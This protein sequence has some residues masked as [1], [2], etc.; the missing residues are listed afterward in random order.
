MPEAKAVDLGEAECVGRFVELSDRVHAAGMAIELVEPRDGVAGAAPTLEDVGRG[1]VGTDV[2]RV[3]GKARGDHEHPRGVEY[4]GR[5]PRGF[6]SKNVK[7]NG[8]SN[9]AN[10]RRR[11]ASAQPE[12]CCVCLATP[13]EGE[14]GVFVM[15]M[16]AEPSQPNQSTSRTTVLS[17]T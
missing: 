10:Y 6:E 11:V 3:P 8:A 9:G 1:L 7:A 4:L 14:A 15:C 5:C 12:E 2:W 17:S 16:L 13:Q